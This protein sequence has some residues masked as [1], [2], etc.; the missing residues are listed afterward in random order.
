MYSKCFGK[1]PE[2]GI[3]EEGKSPSF[4]TQQ[5]RSHVNRPNSFDVH[6][7]RSCTFIIEK[8]YGSLIVQINCRG[9]GSNDK[10]YV[11]HTEH[12]GQWGQHV[13]GSTGFKACVTPFFSAHADKSNE[14]A[15]F[16]K[17]NASTPLALTPF[18]CCGLSLQ[19]FEHPVCARNE[20]GTGTVYD[21]MNIIPWLKY[22][23]FLLRSS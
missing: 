5:V 19:P 2:H 23:S 7:K 4:C 8:S 14:L 1:T 16:R 9:H 13:A 21:L 15:C 17:P 22:V 10:L 11:T 6:Y 3:M 12:S 18:D 20:D